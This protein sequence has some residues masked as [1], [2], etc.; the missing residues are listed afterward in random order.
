MRALL[1]TE[2]NTLLARAG[3][4]Q[5]AFASQTGRN[6]S[7][8]RSSNGRRRSMALI[9]PK[10][11]RRIAS[12]MPRRRDGSCFARVQDARPGTMALAR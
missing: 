8:N 11:G 7:S 3:V 12:P 4:S 1:H 6:R 5:A 9:G 10:S 2:F